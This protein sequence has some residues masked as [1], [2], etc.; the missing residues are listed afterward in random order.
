MFSSCCTRVQ[1][2]GVR[3]VIIS[4]TQRQIA[5]LTRPNSDGGKPGRA[6][7]AHDPSV[8]LVSSSDHSL[9]F[10]VG[11][12]GSQGAIYAC[13]GPLDQMSDASARWTV[14]RA[15]DTY[16]GEFVVN[17]IDEGERCGGV[18]P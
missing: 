18:F 1:H 13:A 14:D 6:D 10:N 16:F 8:M 5:P 7:G 17:P 9:G 15:S 11:M 3:S 12:M 2:L 4:R